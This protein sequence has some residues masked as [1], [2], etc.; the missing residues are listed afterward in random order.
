MYVYVRQEKSNYNKLIANKHV[1]KNTYGHCTDKN[2]NI[3]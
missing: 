1:N 2:F 3:F